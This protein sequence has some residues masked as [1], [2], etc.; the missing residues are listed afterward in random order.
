MENSKL[1]R[2]LAKDCMSLRK[3]LE[4]GLVRAG[5]APKPST[6]TPATS[7]SESNDIQFGVIL[8]SKQREQS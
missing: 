5:S 4:N 7:V 6:I 2:A 1:R 3:K 8:K